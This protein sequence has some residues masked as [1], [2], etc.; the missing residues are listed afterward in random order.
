MNKFILNPL[1]RLSFVVTAGSCVWVV[2]DWVTGPSDVGNL[3]VAGA[4]LYLVA[5]VVVTFGVSIPLNSS[6]DRLDPHAAASAETWRRFLTR[7]TTFNHV[8]TLGAVV[9]CVL[10]TAA[11]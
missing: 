9:A 6:L 10:P 7:W 11:L 5:F 1:F 2:V 8:R 4:L 3:R